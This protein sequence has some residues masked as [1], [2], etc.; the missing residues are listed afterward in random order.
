MA[1]AKPATAVTVAYQLPRRGASRLPTVTVATAS[2]TLSAI[3][4]KYSVVRLPIVSG[5][6]ID[7]GLAGYLRNGT[8][9]TASSA[10]PE[11]RAAVARG[12]KR[13]IRPSAK[14][15]ARAAKPPSAT[16]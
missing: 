15:Y 14:Q 9:Y 8:T 2:R 10:A 5:S 13:P 6:P 7:G 1:T 16:P 12:V 4:R 3:M 11:S